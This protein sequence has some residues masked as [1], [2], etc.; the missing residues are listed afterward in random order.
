MFGYLMTLLAPSLVTEGMMTAVNTAF[1]ADPACPGLGLKLQREALS[2]FR[3]MGIGEV[4]WET[5]TVGGAD[6]I[7]AIYR[8][9][10]AEEKGSVFRLKLVEAA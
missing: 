9:L 3:K 6:R 7:G 1:F 10:G 5:N 4:L 8:R 2:H